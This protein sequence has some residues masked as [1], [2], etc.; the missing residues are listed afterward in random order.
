MKKKHF[1][2]LWGLDILTK[3]ILLIKLNAAIAN[4]IHTL[5]TW[6]YITHK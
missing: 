6:D 5:L 3:M 1:G 4:V 2:T